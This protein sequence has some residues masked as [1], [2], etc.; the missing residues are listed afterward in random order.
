MFNGSEP[1]T[2]EFETTRERIEE[3]IKKVPEGST[4]L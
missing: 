4:W 3:F 1:E 2:F